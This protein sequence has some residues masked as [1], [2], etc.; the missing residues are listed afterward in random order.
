MTQRFFEYFIAD[1]PMTEL[2]EAQALAKGIYVTEIDLD[3]IRHYQSYLDNALDCIIYPD[4]E[5]SPANANLHGARYAGVRRWVVSPTIR[6]GETARRTV[7][8][9]AADGTLEQRTD[10][11]FEERRTTETWF[12]GDGTPGGMLERRYNE[13]GEE[14]EVLEHAPGGRILVHD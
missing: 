6:D 5:P 14:I 9:Y 3:G 12:H 8:V 2:T 11:V 1:E 4:A 13:H 7:W 10:Y